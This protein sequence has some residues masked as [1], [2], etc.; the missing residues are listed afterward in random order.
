MKTSFRLIVSLL[1]VGFLF[2]N[3]TVEAQLLKKL[4]KRAGK[5]AEEAVIRKTEEKVYVE[6]SKKMDTI[7][8]NDGKPDSKKNTKGSKN[9][10]GISSEDGN[11]KS[12]PGLEEVG[13]NEVAFK[14]GSQ[15]L[16]K[17]DFSKDAV[18]DFPAK[19]NT[20]LGGEVK[21]LNGFDMKFLKVPAKSV[22]NL[23]TTKPFPDNF[24][25]ELD[26]IIPE[27]AP[28]RM[29]AIG[30]AEK[31][32]RHIDYMLTNENDIRVM[33]HSEGNRDNDALKF[34]TNNEAL[35]YTYQV[36]KYSIPVNQKFHLAFEVNGNRIRAFVD[37]KK[38]VD[39]PTAYRSAFSNVFFVSAVTHGN[40][41]SLENYFYVSN[42]VIAAT[43]EDLRS[44]VLKD[45]IEK[46]NFTTNE[47]HFAS[48]SDELQASSN[49][50]LNQIGQAMQNNPSI[51]FKIIGHT[52][53]DGDNSSN[54]ILSE[55]RAESVKNY[56]I[57]N[58]NIFSK[59]LVPEGKG[60]SNPVED[61]N[62]PEGKAQNRRV[63][64]VKI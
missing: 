9:T 56:L 17:D 21:K 46:G 30:F 7:L 64:F 41:K 25:A 36:V 20:T 1:V 12:I 54:Q 38:M 44:S 11:T 14:R 52:D 53:S 50:I 8:G 43:G 19:W 34:G 29:A 48:G 6:T 23:E 2:S 45:F 26:I 31:V 27:D 51:K 40:A 49:D 55:K 39:L 15:I 37:G 63:E 16:Y 4:K 13:D 47:I 33:F 57:S 35:G 61:N 32:P 3:Q 59:N 22:I 42:V 62:T 5:A 10:P 24:T 60:E 28:I 18:G 58:F